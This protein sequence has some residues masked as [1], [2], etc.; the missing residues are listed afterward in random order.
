MKTL[1]IIGAGGHGKVVADVALSCGYADILF[2]DSKFPT[3]QE[4]GQWPIIGSIEEALPEPHFCAVGDNQTR[5]HLFEKLPLY[6][7]PTLIHTSCVVSASSKIDFGTVLVAGAIVNAGSYIG[8]GVIINTA[9][10]VDHDCEIGDFVHIAPGA[11][12]GG[13]V[14]IGARSWVGLGAVVREGINIGSDVVIGAGAAVISDVPS[15]TRFVGVP[16]K[17]IKGK[18]H[19]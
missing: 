7:S 19:E 4:N 3:K 14:S 16:A 5:E 8:R 9:A 12:L 17:S 6:D 11:R 2:L 15:G 18:V 10:S 1:H 13:N